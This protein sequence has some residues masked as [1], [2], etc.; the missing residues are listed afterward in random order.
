MRESD[1]NQVLS[2]SAE[3][4]PTTTPYDISSLIGKGTAA[5]L[6]TQV[7]NLWY[8]VRCVSLAD[9]QSYNNQGSN[10]A[11][12]YGDGDG[13]QF[14][15]FSYT[16]PTS[17]ANAYRI[18]YDADSIGTSLAVTDYPIPD[19]FQ[20]YIELLAM[21]PL[22]VKIR[23]NLAERCENEAERELLN[24]KLQTWSDLYAENKRQIMED[25]KP[26]WDTWKN[27]SRTAQTQN[28][29]PSRSGRGFYGGTI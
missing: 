13:N 16:P 2:L 24:V 9:L 17:D 22:I 28:R 14:I 23:K 18:R 5:W 20:P 12:F 3:F 29:L 7:N 4:T 11:S 25:W 21:Q 10:A 6:E 8:P 1:N 15:A 27:R 19:S 26:L